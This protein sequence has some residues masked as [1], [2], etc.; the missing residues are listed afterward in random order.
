MVADFGS[1]KILPE[2]YDYDRVQADIDQRR[3]EAEAADKNGDGPA[4]RPPRRASFVGTAQYVSP[5][6][7]KGNAVHL[8]T[9]LWSFGC[10]IYQMLA[11][12]TP[13]KGPTEYLIFQKILN[14]EYDFPENF[15]ESA[16]DLIT[17]LLRFNPR[18]RLGFNDP[19]ENMYQSIKNHPFFKDIDWNSNLYRQKPPEMN[20]GA[21]TNGNDGDGDDFHIAH[22][23][24]PGLGEDQLKRILQDEFG[25]STLEEEEIQEPSTCKLVFWDFPTSVEHF[26][27][28]TIILCLF[29]SA[30]LETLLEVQRS[31]NEWADFVEPSELIL[32]HG[33]VQKKKKGPYITRTRMLILTSKPRLIYIDPFAKVKKGEIPFESIK[34]EAKNFKLFFLHTVSG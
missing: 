3:A 27:K 32:R 10:I 18:D 9:D 20:R 11:G 14:V 13:F 17:K 2:D 22:N 25:S 8:A 34:A 16:K 19:K 29:L 31:T 24:E 28:K 21:E 23:V 4:V 30:A 7:L 15:N 6:I 5:E 1:S 26:S 33:L 12:T